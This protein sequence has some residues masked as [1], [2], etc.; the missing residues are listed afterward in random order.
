MEAYSNPSL[1]SISTTRRPKTGAS[2][3]K[4]TRRHTS[5]ELTNLPS[6]GGA[7]EGGVS[8]TVGTVWIPTPNQGLFKPKPGLEIARN[9]AFPGTNPPGRNR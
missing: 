8:R 5:N 4:K 6:V 9:P 3:Y 1:A 2:R 7:V